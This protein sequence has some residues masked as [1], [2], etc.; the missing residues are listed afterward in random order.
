MRRLAAAL[1]APLAITA[2]LAG[3]SSGSSA[4][5]DASVTVSGTAGKAPTVQIP[6]KA[7][8]GDLVT[9]TLIKGNGPVITASDSFLGQFNVY[10][11]HGTTHKLLYT[12]FGKT[13]QILPVRIGVTGL[14][15]AVTGQRVGS[16]VLAVVPPKYG[17]GAQGNSSAGIGA[18][19]TMVW[20]IDLIKSYPASASASGKPV[21]TGGGNLPEVTNQPGHAPVIT[22]PSGKTPPSKLASVVLI[23]GTGAPVKAGQS[24]TVKYTG[25]IWRNSQVFDTNWPT[26][27]SGT[28]TPPPRVFTLTATSLIPGWV[29]GLTGVPV[30]S[31]VLLVVPPADGYGKSGYPSI[32]IKGTDTLVFVIDILAAS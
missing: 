9:K 24:I 28:T 29:T 8:S 1:L 27:T 30:G 32:G 3:C 11:W 12:T 6:S 18:A 19:D 20:V 5:A 14:E 26:A 7:A 25:E 23:Q 15:R 31:R 17:Y 2:A 16:R 21:S 10:L 13:A 22:I 4:T